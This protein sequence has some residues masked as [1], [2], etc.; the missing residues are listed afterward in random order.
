VKKK[1]EEKF[2]TTTIEGKRGSPAE[3]E[4]LQR[5]KLDRYEIRSQG[6][7][8]ISDLF[9]PIPSQKDKQRSKTMIDLIPEGLDAG[10]QKNE[11]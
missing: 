1:S 9:P 6:G 10:K 2:D 5:I 4:A 8:I 3:E 7:V 11:R